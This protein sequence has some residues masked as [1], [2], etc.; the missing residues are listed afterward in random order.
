M[1]QRLYIIGATGNGLDAIDTVR[2]INAACGASRFDVAGVLDDAPHR[3][4]T[5][6]GGVDVVGTLSQAQAIASADEKAIFVNSIGSTNTYWKR[7][8]LIRSIG[9]PREKYVS[10]IHPSASVSSMSRLGL[11]CLIFR[12]VSICADAEIGDHALILA[13]SVV[14]HNSTVGDSSTLATAV[15]VS[16]HVKIGTAAYMG[17]NA[18]LHPHLNIGAR[19]LVGMGAVVLK[20]VPDDAVVV[21]NPARLLRM[22]QP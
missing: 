7:D 18:C 9:L 22:R 20:D 19:S 8:A 13:N 1:R 14:S 21:G 17:A 10:L 5:A 12:N 4:G 16:G 3:L 11:G 15:C 6:H 2:D